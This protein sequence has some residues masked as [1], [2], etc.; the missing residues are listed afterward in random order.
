MTTTATANDNNNGNAG[1]GGEDCIM[2]TTNMALKA[3][4]VVG[5]WADEKYR[6]AIE[7]VK[8]DVDTKK[9]ASRQAS[10]R[11]SKASKHERES[12]IVYERLQ[13]E[14]EERARAAATAAA[15]QQ[16]HLINQLETERD[17]AKDRWDE[18]QVEE[19]KAM[20]ASKPL[21]QIYLTSS[22]KLEAIETEQRQFHG[23][24]EDAVR[25]IQLKQIRAIGA[26][27]AAAAAGRSHRRTPSS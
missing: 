1:G 6:V 23:S 16:Q 18:A 3:I 10:K 27:A 2:Y 21:H 25:A 14:L 12:R 11:S 7:P 20:Y 24:L 5:S 17:E 9:K 15:E 19:E 22:L 4:D 13:R 26:E 8:A